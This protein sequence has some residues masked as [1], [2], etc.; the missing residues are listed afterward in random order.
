MLP[1]GGQ[2][3]QFRQAGDGP[4]SIRNAPLSHG[5]RAWPCPLCLSGCRP[6]RRRHR[7]NSGPHPF[8]RR[9]SDKQSDAPRSGAEGCDSG[10]VGCL[11]REVRKP[12]GGEKTRAAAVSEA[13]IG[14]REPAG[15]QPLRAQSRLSD[16]SRLHTTAL[17]SA[18]ARSRSCAL[19][20]V[21]TRRESHRT[22]L[23]TNPSGGRAW[24]SPGSGGAE[25]SSLKRSSACRQPV[26]ARRPGPAMHQSACSCRHSNVDTPPPLELTGI[27]GRLLR[28]GEPR[29]RSAPRCPI[30]GGHNPRHW[31]IA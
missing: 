24:L 27:Q 9:A 10:A 20:S 2:S 31:V 11:P 21:S 3:A 7:V 18:E 29:D 6:Q 19:V 22:E 30:G 16:L 28:W 8:R 13:N 25:R 14:R 4:V 15:L 23:A 1:D 5:R 12:M 26:R 17:P